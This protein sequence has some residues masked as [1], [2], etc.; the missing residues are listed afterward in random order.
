[1]ARVKDKTS[2]LADVKITIFD[3][4]SKKAFDEGKRLDLIKKETHISLAFP[5]L[6]PGAYFIVIQ[7][8]DRVAN[9]VDVYSGMIRL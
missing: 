2:G 6:K 1:M 8:Y 9:R 5:Q 7:A 3:E 4:A